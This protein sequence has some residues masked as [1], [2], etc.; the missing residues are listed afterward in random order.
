MLSACAGLA[1]GQRS[2]DIPQRQLLDGLAKQFPVNA[3]YLDLLDVRLDRPSLR[4][5]PESNRLGTALTLSASERLF[6][7]TLGG[8]VDITYGLRIEP[9]DNTIRLADVRVE[10]LDIAGLPAQL[11]DQTQRLGPFLAQR[12]LENVAVYT[13]KPEDLA[14][15]RR[16]GYVPGE[17]RVVPSGLQITLNPAQ[18]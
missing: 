12:L 8:T 2:I 11:R 5:M 7:S 14:R 10:R 4:L 15:A 18:P 17:V 16:W 13:F 1:P 3:R 9:A 6:R